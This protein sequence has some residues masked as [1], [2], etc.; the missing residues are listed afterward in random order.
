ML[1]VNVDPAAATTPHAARDVRSKLVAAAA[2]S[3]Q[4][5]N[6]PVGSA[7]G[8]NDGTVVGSTVGSGTGA[9]GMYEGA[10]LGSGVGRIVR[11][12]WMSALAT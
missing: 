3:W 11:D 10:K 2:Y 9:P 12:V 5:Y 6:V 7:V 1:T 4:V 8:I